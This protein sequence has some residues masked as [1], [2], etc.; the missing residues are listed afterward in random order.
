MNQLPLLDAIQFQ[1]AFSIGANVTL[2]A[3][4]LRNDHLIMTGSGIYTPA[5]ATYHHA[6]RGDPEEGRLLVARVPVLDPL[7]AGEIT[8]TEEGAVWD[9][10]TPSLA[11]DS[12]YC[13]SESCTDPPSAPDTSAAPPSFPTFTASMMYDLFTF[14]LLNK[15]EDKLEVCD[16]RLCCQLQ[17]KRTAQ[18]ETK[19]VYALGAFAGTHTV[20]GRYALQ[21]DIL[22]I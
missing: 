5:S 15:T 11:T 18:G 7:W 17:Y 22:N 8:A 4:N 6:M 21:V 16:G 20:N 12:S 19:E 14:V 13:H 2:L 1:R 10:S 9:D 3:A